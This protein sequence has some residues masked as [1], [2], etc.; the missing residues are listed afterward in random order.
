VPKRRVKLMPKGGKRVGAGR[1]R[2]APAGARQ[3]NIIVTDEER[4]ILKPIVDKLLAD[5]RK[6]SE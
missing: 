5:L 4:A 2:V 1:K 3:W 6:P